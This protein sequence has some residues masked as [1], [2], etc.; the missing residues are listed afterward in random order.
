MLM[1]NSPPKITPANIISSSNTTYK[2]QPYT[3]Y[4]AY[5]EQGAKP[6]Q[7]TNVLAVGTNIIASSGSPEHPKHQSMI[8]KPQAVP[9]VTR[10]KSS[11]VSKRSNQTTTGA[12]GSMLKM[13]TSSFNPNG[14]LH[15][16]SNVIIENPVT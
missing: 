7:A 10:L 4:E 6:I 3:N 13:M 8:L 5:I 15:I 16:N 9:G 12:A 11:A 2:P 1:S 14:H